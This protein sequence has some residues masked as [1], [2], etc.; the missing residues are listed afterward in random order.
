MR[1][2]LRVKVVI[3]LWVVEL[4]IISANKYL[5]VRAIACFKYSGML[6]RIAAATSGFNMLVMIPVM[7]R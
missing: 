5:S 1:Q 2:A 3:C 4:P 6:I 7:A